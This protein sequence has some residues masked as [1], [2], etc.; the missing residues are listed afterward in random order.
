MAL[1]DSYKG[2]TY[3]VSYEYTDSSGATPKT[4]RQVALV[5]AGSL[6]GAA[7]LAD[8]QTNGWPLFTPAIPSGVTAI[9]VFSIVRVESQEDTVAI[10]GDGTI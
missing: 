9:N 5:A 2:N 1:A 8:D 7:A 6:A 4:V 10:S 3:R